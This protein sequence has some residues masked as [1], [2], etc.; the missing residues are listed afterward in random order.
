[1][2]SGH[3]IETDPPVEPPINADSPLEPPAKGPS[4]S[5]L[6]PALAILPA[7][8][9]LVVW[10]LSLRHVSVE[11]LDDYGLP[12]ALPPAWYAAL[13]TCTLGAVA[14]LCTRRPRGWLV[15]LYIGA[16]IAILFATVPVLSEVPHYSWS[17]KHFGVTSYLE[18]HGATNPNVDIYNR[19]PGFFAV[20]AFFS[21]VAGHANPAS[22]AAWFEVV[23]VTLDAILIVAAIRAIHPDTRVAGGA[24]LFFVLGNWVG[25]NYYSPQ[26]FTFLLSLGV[27]TIIL[28][29]LRSESPSRL[30][31]R[32]ASIIE[33]L[34]RAPQEDPRLPSPQWPRAAAIAAAIGVDIVIIASHQLTPYILLIDAALLA[35]LGILRPRWIVLIMAGLTLFYLSLNFEYI[36]RNFGIFTSLD[37]FSNA[38]HSSLYDLAP[39]PGKDFNA[40]AG[41]LSALTVW[42]LTIASMLRLAPQ[43]LALR[44]MPFAL[45]A[46]APFIVILGQNYGG[47]ASLRVILFS[48]PWCGA[49]TVWAWSTLRSRALS[50]ILACAVATVMAAFF[51]PAYLGAEEL[52]LMPQ[53]EVQASHYFYEHAEP[54]T[55]LMLS[56]PNFPIRYSARYNFFTGPKGDDDP[57]LLRTSRFRERPLGPADVSSVA[58]VIH[59]YAPRGYILFSTTSNRYAKVFRLT[60]PGALSDLE[61]AV[62]KSHIF[63]LWYSDPDVRIYELLEPGKEPAR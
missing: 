11:N 44:A 29:H 18:L 8:I 33:R 9:A 46:F 35:V 51:I 37:P 15:A 42:L 40:L 22:Y 17:Y 31:I 30:W 39:Q 36:Q 10:R 62:A 56:G 21:L 53:S 48:L 63:R 7:L 2:S 27:V 43:G 26:A 38:K 47:E 4:G 59:Q 19:W 45:L 60:P 5:R 20:S 49:L 13:A 55:V 25:Q 28:R 52:N 61:A 50:A 54:G 14:T 32:V 23:F 24:V 57:N 3:T 16:V 12:P 6:L 41:Q 1:M 34:S 58:D